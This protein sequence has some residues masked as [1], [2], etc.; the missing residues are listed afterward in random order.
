MKVAAVLDPD[1]T[2][3]PKEDSAEDHG[4]LYL[5]S[6]FEIIRTLNMF[7]SDSASP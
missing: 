7:G 2:P 3:I 5:D 4:C 1:R 6:A